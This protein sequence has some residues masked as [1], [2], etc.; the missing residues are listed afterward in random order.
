MKTI[1]R[2]FKRET[3][4]PKTDLIAGFGY[5]S[6]PLFKDLLKFCRTL[7]KEN[8]HLSSR[9]KLLGNKRVTRGRRAARI[10][11]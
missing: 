5:G 3:D 11:R 2:R 1:L 9:V 4:T 10:L 7:E 8:T 6:D